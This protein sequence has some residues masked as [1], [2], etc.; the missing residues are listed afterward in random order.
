MWPQKVYLLLFVR[1]SEECG[2]LRG[3][4]LSEECVASKGVPAPVCTLE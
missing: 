3:V 2:V 4:R 1:S